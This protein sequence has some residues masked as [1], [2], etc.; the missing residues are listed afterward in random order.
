MWDEKR[1]K[2][3]SEEA[4]ET[5]NAHGL[6]E[7][8]DLFVYLCG[9]GGEIAE[10][11][12]SWNKEK[13]DELEE[14]ADVI[15]RSFTTAKRFGASL[16]IDKHYTKD[17]NTIEFPELCYRAYRLLGSIT[18]YTAELGAGLSRIIS[19]LVN[20]LPELEKITLEKMAYNKTRPFKH[21]QNKLV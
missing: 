15:I 12:D 9:I 17:R 19:L 13:G 11:F 20:T 6:C 2:Q 3:L 21:G 1:L 14:L 8:N 10:A 16:F 18:P 7:S 5:A 4:Y